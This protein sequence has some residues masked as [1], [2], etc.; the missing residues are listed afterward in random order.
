L[1][2]NRL[3]T[4]IETQKG[5]EVSIEEFISSKKSQMAFDSNIAGYGIMALLVRIENKG[6]STYRIPRDQMT[7]VLDGAPP[8]ERLDGKEAASQGANRDYAG[9]ALGWTLA[10]GPFALLFAPLTLAGSQAHTASV[11]KTIEEHF[12]TLE[13]PDALLKPKE[14]VSGFIYFKLPFGLKRLEK[15]MV[16]IQPMDEVSGEKL[17]YKFS[18]PSLDIELPHSRRERKVSENY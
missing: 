18:L 6:N 5:L 2:R 12:G 1:A 17:S 7:A 3:P 16:E 14:S 13:F 8:L 11:N 15:A 9:R 10:T 4:A